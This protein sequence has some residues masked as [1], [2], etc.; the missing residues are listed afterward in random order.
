MGKILVLFL[1]LSKMFFCSEYYFS[2][3][4]DYYYYFIVAPFTHITIFCF[5]GM[6]FESKTSERL[7]QRIAQRAAE[8]RAQQG[9][10]AQPLAAEVDRAFEAPLPADLPPII[11]SEKKATCAQSSASEP[12]PP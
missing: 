12:E 7:R 11:D 2:Y 8:L 6:T 1:F 10:Q 4:C 9:N 3:L 5:I